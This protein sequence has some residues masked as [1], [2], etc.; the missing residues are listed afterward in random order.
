MLKGFL[1]DCE[2]NSSHEIEEAI[3]KVWD[4]LTFDKVQSV[5]HNWMNRLAWVIENGESIFLNKREMVSSYIVNLKIGG[6]RELSLHPVCA[7]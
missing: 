7:V 3:M 5:F 1:N 6:G 2:F 4:E